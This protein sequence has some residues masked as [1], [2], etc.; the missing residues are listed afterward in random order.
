MLLQTLLQLNLLI[1]ATPALAGWSVLPVYHA[2]TC[3]VG[4]VSQY[5]A[6]EAALPV[7]EAAQAVPQAKTPTVPLPTPTGIS[8]FAPA[9]A[10]V[11]TLDCPFS[12]AARAP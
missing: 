8:V 6:A 12:H 2:N 1:L 7:M 9:P 5:R 3:I 11:L 4:I 10:V